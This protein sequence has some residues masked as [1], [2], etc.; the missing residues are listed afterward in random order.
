MGAPII[1]DNRFDLWVSNGTK[2]L[3]CDVVVAVAK[4]EGRDIA[5]VYELAPGIAGTYGVSGLGID[6]DEFYCY[7][8][9]RDGF[10]RHLDVCSRRVAEVCD[11]DRARVTMANVIAWTK[12]L[13][14]GGT[15]V[16]RPNFHDELPPVL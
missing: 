8:G 2:D 3:F 9:G 14:D 15:I 16:G 5:A 7:F 6:V 10:R 1:I 11:N 13:M 12:Y 4:L